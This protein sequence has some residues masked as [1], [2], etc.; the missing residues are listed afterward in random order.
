MVENE[1]LAAIAAAIELND[2]PVVIAAAIASMETRPGY[3]LV[4]R[5]MRQ[6]PQSSPIWNTAGRFERL[7]QNLNS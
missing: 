4:V 7:K 1:V 5:S 3:K 2:I 6:V